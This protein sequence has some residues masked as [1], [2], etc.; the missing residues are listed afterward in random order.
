[1]YLHHGNWAAVLHKEGLYERQQC[2]PPIIHLHEM[3]QYDIGQHSTNSVYVAILVRTKRHSWLDC[4]QP[5]RE[6]AKVPL[7]CRG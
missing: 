6:A 7:S 5:G 3:K 1:M 4:Q 2:A